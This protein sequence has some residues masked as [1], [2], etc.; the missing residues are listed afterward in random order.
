MLGVLKSYRSRGIGK[1]LMIHAM[2][3][4]EEQG[5]DEAKLYVDDTNIT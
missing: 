5:M 3:F 2:K 1:A 4:L